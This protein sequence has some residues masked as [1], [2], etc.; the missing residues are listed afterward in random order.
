[1]GQDFSM[2]DW[3]FKVRIAKAGS[4]SFTKYQAHESFARNF[5]MFGTF[6]GLK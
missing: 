4:A 3:Q 2:S 1:M 6:R 5:C